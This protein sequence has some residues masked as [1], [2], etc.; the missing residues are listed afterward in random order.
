M[1]AP[2]AAIA[3]HSDV[4]YLHNPRPAYPPLARKLGLEGT[5]T[6]RI[7][8]SADGMPEQSRIIATSGAESL[9]AAALEVVQR[10]RF[11]PARDG[12]SAIAH[13]VDVPVTFKLARQ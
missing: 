1:A 4:G 10:W 7:L 8:V 5:V 9:D 13:W 2:R 6:L 11:I 3:Q 12:R